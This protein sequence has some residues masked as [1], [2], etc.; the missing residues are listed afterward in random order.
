MTDI[1]ERPTDLAAE[2]SWSRDEQQ[3]AAEQA[4]NEF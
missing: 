2:A 1:Y 4:D 3:D